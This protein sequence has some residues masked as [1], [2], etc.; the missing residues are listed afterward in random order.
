[1]S[2]LFPLFLI[3]GATL[4]IPVLI[5]LFNLRRYKTVFFPHTRFLKN[6]Q[7]NS[8]RQSQVR[9][10]WLLFFRLLF[11][12]SLIF[13]FAQPFFK[14]DNQKDTGNRLQ[15]IYLD[16]SYSM[17][18]KS[19]ARRLLDVARDA[20]IKQIQKSRTGSK[21]ILLT[22]DKP[23]SY[24]PMMAD[25]ML[26]LLNA[27][28]ISASNKS[29]E[30]VLSSV[31]SLMQNESLPA[32]DVYYYSDFQRTAFATPKDATLMKGIQ[33][34]GVPVQAENAGNVFIDTA[35]LSMPVLQ[36]GQ[37][38]KLIVVTKTEGKLPADA[39]VLQLNVNGQVKSATTLKFTAENESTDTLSFTVNDAGWQ[40]MMLTVNDA[41]VR[42]DDTFRIA[43]RSAPSLSI[44][45]LNEGQPSP[46]IQAAFRA[47]NGFRILQEDV[48]NAPKDFAAYNLVIVNGI[49]RMDATFGKTLNN[50]LQAGQSVCIFPGRTMNVAALNEGLKTITD[51]EI[52]SV[53]TAQQAATSLQQGSDLVKDLFE[54]IP[55]NVQLPTANWHYIIKAGLSANEQSILSFRNGDPFIA[56][57]TPSRGQLYICATS[58]DLQSGNFPGSYFF[59]P[60]LYEMAVQSKGGDVYAITSGKLQPAYIPLNN[61][62]ERNMVHVYG[63]GINAIPTQRSSGAG[64]NVYLDQTVQQPGFYQLAAQG[65]DTTNIGLNADRNESAMGTWTASE[66]KNQWKTGGV[67]WL[68]LNDAGVFSNAANTGNFPLWKVCAI[69]AL[70]MLCAETFVLAGSLRKQTVATQ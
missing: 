15:V 57:Y 62:D 11:L 27:V 12:A 56:R 65:S 69:L 42:F 47:Y 17:S 45:V 1:M 39:P 43:A 64:L 58:A 70:F 10:K 5:H 30:Q 53:D 6:I 46:Y 26:S 2:F 9:Y 51:L 55:E 32:A 36:T 37:T 4:A 67:K 33:F 52:S 14:S 59:V 63:N 54:K 31:Q 35:Y 23:Q 24:Q 44:L 38:N 19:G 16:N 25:K 22:N 68:E 50:A 29:A 20:A 13:A 60:F 8:R 7:L 49:T 28:D 48:H 61:A 40:Q 34:F 18:V 41:S 66:L 21:F 3:A